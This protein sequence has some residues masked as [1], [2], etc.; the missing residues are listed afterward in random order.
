[1]PTAPELLALLSELA[2]KPLTRT[3]LKLMRQIL[4]RQ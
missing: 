1:M 3:V 2:S 4:E